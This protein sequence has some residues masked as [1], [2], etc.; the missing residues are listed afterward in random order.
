MVMQYAGEYYVLAHRRHQLLHAEH[1]ARAKKFASWRRQV[2]A[3][4]PRLRIESMPIGSS[5]IAIGKELTVSARVFLDSLTPDDVLVQI[6]E[7]H[8]D[9]GG[10]IQDPVITPMKAQGKDKSGGVLFRAALRS[11]KSGLRGYAIRVLPNHP[12]AV[13]SF[14]PG[15][16][17]WATES[18]VH[19]PELRLR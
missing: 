19:S 12:D 11:A 2:E 18:P 5:E 10:E 9:A 6:L 17:L 16:I 3:A 1:A 14:I 15:L 8:V 13:T 4:W 7:G